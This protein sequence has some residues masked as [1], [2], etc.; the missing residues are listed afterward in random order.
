MIPQSLPT[1]FTLLAKDLAA[2]HVFLSVS[3]EQYSKACRR[4]L[5]LGNPPDQLQPPPR[6][7]VV[8]G[9]GASH[10][11]CG[12]PLGKEAAEELKRRL[13][14]VNE[15]LLQEELDRLTLEYRLEKTDFETLLLALGKF[16]Q[17][18]LLLE[19]H[20]IFFRR[21]YPN[22]TYEILAHLLKHRFLDAIVNFNFDE[23]L[24]Q[25]ID[26]E[27]GTGNYYRVVSDGDGLDEISEWI[28]QRKRFRLPVYIKPHGTASQKSSLRFTRSLYTLLPSEFTGLLKALFYPK[29]G[30]VKVLVLGHAMQSIEFNALLRNAHKDTETLFIDAEKPKLEDSLGK[31]YREGF[32]QVTQDRPLSAQMEELWEATA[33][34]FQDGY[35]PRRVSRHKLISR[36]FARTV[37]FKHPESKNQ[38][39]LVEY[40]K[41]RA[42]LELAIAI[43]KAKGFV[44]LHQLSSGRAGDYFRLYRRR[45]PHASTVSLYKMCEKLGLKQV[46]YSREALRLGKISDNPKQPLSSLIVKQEDLEASLTELQMKLEGCL[47]ASLW[48]RFQNEREL[49]NQTLTEMY[50]GDEVEVG[51]VKNVGHHEAFSD[52][53]PL[54]TMTA[55]KEQTVELLEED[56]WDALLVVAETGQWLTSPSLVRILQGKKGKLVVVVADDTLHKEL[57]ERFGSQL[58]LFR[59]LPWWLHNQHMTLLLEGQEVKRGI[60]FERRLRSSLIM[61]LGVSA[62]NDTSALLDAFVAYLMKAERYENQSLGR[63][64]GETALKQERRRFLN[65]LYKEPDDPSR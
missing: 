44:H 11:A 38:S 45:A 53:L 60:Y 56:D 25:A 28:D 41:D 49:L 1:R 63:F 50:K 22:F 43:A 62:S 24:D 35:E 52:P 16:D 2:N 14:R 59:V 5:N 30:P 3:N 27:V 21:H 33:M 54:H 23:L 55:L 58:H 47:S 34:F 42:F 19:L 15:D 40:L 9:A 12:L 8:V 64:I 20:N 17:Q 32:C 7:V 37:D 13:T 57:Q 10:A 48:E 46:G 6:V 29:Q 39:E 61:P 65:D 36:L 51:S 18:Q 26:D 4:V 31:F